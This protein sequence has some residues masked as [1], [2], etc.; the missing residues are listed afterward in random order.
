MRE[1][2]VERLGRE[3]KT[4]VVVTKG[5][6]CRISYSL[7]PD[8]LVDVAPLPIFA[9]LGAFDDRMFRRVKMLG[10]VLIFRTVAATHVATVQTFAQMDPG[11]TDLQAIF[12]TVR[13]RLDG[14]CRIQMSTSGGHSYSVAFDRTGLAFRLPP[15][16]SIWGS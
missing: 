6:D 2:S 10:G 4:A 8:D 5:R 14:A 12:T 11:V 15:M 7:R 9:W 16:P 13:R 1:A 3:V